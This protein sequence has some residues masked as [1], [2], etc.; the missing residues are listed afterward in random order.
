MSAASTVVS[1]HIA[2]TGAA[3]MQSVDQVRAVAGRGLEGDRYFSKLG[4]YSNDPGTGRDV[5]L[6]EI[7]A[8][9]ALKREYDLD[10]APGLS[11][12]NM[13]TRGVALNHLVG[14]EF[15]IGEVVLRGM[16]LCEPCAHLE[17]LTRQG[18]MRGLI[19][20]GGLR[21]EIVSGGTI[22]IDDSIVPR[23]EHAA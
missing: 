13:V 2:P 9:E 12:R 16:R 15:T 22:H 14:R 18:V 4:T 6:I 11:R 19:H 8:I 21:A 5:T 17:K 3:T 1:L 23:G 10:M 7:E 20:R